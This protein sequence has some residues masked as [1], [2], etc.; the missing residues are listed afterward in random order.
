ML[1]FG[2]MLL[3]LVNPLG[4]AVLG[5]EITLVSFGRVVVLSHDRYMGSSG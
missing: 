4:N 1:V 3:G 2:A 5:S